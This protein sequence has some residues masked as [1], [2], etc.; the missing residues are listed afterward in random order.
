MIEAG[1]FSNKEI[2]T[3]AHTTDRSIRSIRRNIRI[4][5]QTLVSANKAGTLAT[6]TDE[7]VHFGSRCQISHSTTKDTK[8]I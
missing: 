7:I 8:V 6:M 4:F 2:A 3:A 5:G 1:R